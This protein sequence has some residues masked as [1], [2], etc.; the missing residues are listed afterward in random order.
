[1]PPA[2]HLVQKYFE[3]EAA[4]F[5]AIYDHNKPLHQ[6][7]GDAL[8]RRVILERFSLVVNAVAAPGASILDVGCGPGH[9]GVE[10]A[11]RGASRCHGVDISSEM[12][13]LA[14]Q[15]AEAA[16]VAD[17]CTWDL[18][19]FLAA[20]VSEPFD[21]VLAMGYFDYLED[22]LPHLQKMIGAAR[23]QVFA[24]FPKRWGLRAGMRKLR[25]QLA[26]GFV[27][28]Y[29]RREVLNL[30]RQCGNL[31]ALSVVDLGRDNVVIYNTAAAR[32]LQ[33][34]GGDAQTFPGGAR[35]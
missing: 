31:A 23:K 28:F 27:R 13:Q 25:F 35:R 6:R 7:L 17:R 21:V 34:L 10:L 22:P 32:A 1:M 11:R 15:R 14:Q 30:F 18:S 5:Q 9:Y 8:F 19:D 3:R 29:T 20:R 26:H 2:V 24:S 12:L 33:P 4:R 16:A